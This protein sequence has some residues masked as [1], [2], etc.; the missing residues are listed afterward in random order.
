MLDSHIQ[1]GMEMISTIIDPSLYCRFEN[2]QIIG[3][4]ISY[5]DDVLRTGANKWMS[6]ADST[7]ERF[8]TTGDDQPP[9][10]FAGLNITEKQDMLNIDQDFYLNKI[11]QTSHEAEF[12][13]FPP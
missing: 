13:N 3:I 5:A 8:E 7:L 2:N 10:I 4:N 1:I 12:S 9:F 11:E 6:Q